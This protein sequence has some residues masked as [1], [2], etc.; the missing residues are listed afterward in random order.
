MGS[1]MVRGSGA[2]AGGV[3]QFLDK[4]VDEFVVVLWSFLGIVQLLDKV[5]DMP[6]AV[7]QFVKVVDD[8]VVQVVVVS[9]QLDRFRELI[10]ESSA[11]DHGG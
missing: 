5:A 10:V 9:V 4:V 6:V 1:R 3:V 8:P 7:P 11:T 2:A